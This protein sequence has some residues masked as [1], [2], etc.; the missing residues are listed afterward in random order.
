MT[1]VAQ[2]MSLRSTP[3]NTGYNSVVRTPDFVETVDCVVYGDDLGL[4][5][6]ARANYI[7]EDRANEKLAQSEKS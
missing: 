1:R 7:I 3:W 6:T 2:G 5:V 4:F